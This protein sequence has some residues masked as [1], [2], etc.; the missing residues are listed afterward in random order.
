MRA[1]TPQDVETIVWLERVE[2]KVGR[3]SDGADALR[4]DCRIS[5][6]DKTLGVMTGRKTLLGGDPPT[7]KSASGPGSGAD[8]DSMAIAKYLTSLPRR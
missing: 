5:I 4:E 8:P 7:Y 2:V 1:S 3:Y 6:I